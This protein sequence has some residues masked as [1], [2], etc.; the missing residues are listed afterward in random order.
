[1][2]ISELSDISSLKGLDSIKIEIENEYLNTICFCNLIHVQDTFDFDDISTVNRDSSYVFSK[3]EEPINEF[4]GFLKQNGII[5]DA[6]SKS[7]KLDNY[8]KTISFP[9]NRK[10]LIIS[11][12]TEHF[13]HELRKEINFAWKIGLFTSTLI[14]TR[15]Y[16]ENLVI[17]VLRKKYPQRIGSNINIYFDNKNKR[18]HDF[19]IL[20]D[21]L[22]ERKDDFEPD[23][24]LILKFLEKVK[25]F[26][27]KA[28]A[29]THSI[30]ENPEE[31][32][33]TKLPILVVFRYVNMVK[34][35][36][37]YRHI[38]NDHK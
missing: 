10:D 13:Y 1:M 7:Y 28:N 9:S 5:Y 25:P 26:K 4:L 29:T 18:F 27:G 11:I 20:L 32:Y 24:H 35:C 21:N 30:V 12:P 17:D 36:L 34:W 3:D 8:R 14:L 33:L 38:I 16:I 23:T 37:Y 15:K 19:S 31:N 6:T 22:A 2:D